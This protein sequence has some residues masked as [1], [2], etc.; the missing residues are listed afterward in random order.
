[1]GIQLQ[2]GEP[3]LDKGAGALNVRLAFLLNE[4]HGAL[5]IELPPADSPAI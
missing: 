5:R 2:E 3:I 1:M 4:S